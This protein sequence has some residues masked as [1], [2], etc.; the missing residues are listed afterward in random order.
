M[1]LFDVIE[2]EKVKKIESL[3]GFKVLSQV[4]FS[5]FS[6]L[7]QFS[8][9]EKSFILLKTFLKNFKKKCHKTFELNKTLKVKAIP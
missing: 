4:V 5:Q 2:K 7:K 6:I 3:E 1:S 8:F 9:D